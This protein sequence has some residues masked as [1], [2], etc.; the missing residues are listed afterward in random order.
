MT[1]LLL[2]LLLL[3]IEIPVVAYSY[4]MLG[5]GVISRGMADCG[6][7]YVKEGPLRGFSIQLVY[8]AL[9]APR[10]CMNPFPKSSPTLNWLSPSIKAGMWRKVHDTYISH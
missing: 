5:S 2:L 1:V 6:R 8:S 3:L 7:L 9:S 10:C 4:A